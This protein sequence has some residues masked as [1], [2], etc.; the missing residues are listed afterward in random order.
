MKKHFYSRFARGFMVA[1]LTLTAVSAKADLIGQ[2]VVV[3][4]DYP[5]IGS[6]FATLGTGTVTAGGLTFGNPP[7]STATSD[8]TVFAAQLVLENVFDE[9]LNYGSATFNGYVLTETGGSP[10]AITGVSIDSA[11]NVSGFTSSDV[12]FD[13]TDVYLN[14]QGLQPAPMQEVVLD[15]NIGSISSVPEPGTVGLLYGGLLAVLCKASRRTRFARATRGVSLLGRNNSRPV[16]A[17][18]SSPARVKIPRASIAALL[19][20]FFPHSVRQRV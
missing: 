20:H 19:P 2:Q 16:T 10:V 8:Y 4:Y 1:A 6:V 9:T 17:R 18:I 15:L 14:M 7:M 13:S 12:S 3:D 5:T 11:T